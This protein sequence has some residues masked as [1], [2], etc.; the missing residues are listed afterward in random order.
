MVGTSSVS[1]E[2]YETSVLAEAREIL[3]SRLNT[4]DFK[5]N[6]NELVKDYLIHNITEKEHEVFGCLFLNN[7]YRLI[8]DQIIF[9]GT[10]DGASVYPREVAKEA[11]LCNAA[12]VIFYHNHPSGLNE[13][14]VADKA[15]TTRLKDALN[16]VDIRVL[17]HIIV[18]GVDAYCFAEHGLI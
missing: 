11:L 13:P 18:A 6:N 1:K 14:S 5:A 7:Q 15:I 16:T 3:K 12:A 10:I 8:K 2:T 17:D 4:H 9:R